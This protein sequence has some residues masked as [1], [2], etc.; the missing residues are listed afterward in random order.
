MSREDFRIV[1]SRWAGR[2]RTGATCGCAVA[3]ALRVLLAIWCPGSLSGR[4]KDCLQLVNCLAKLL[5]PAKYF[6]ISMT[7]PWSEIGGT[8]SM[9][10]DELCSAVFRVLVQKL[11]QNLSRDP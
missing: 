3:V 7:F 6:A 4:V 11:F 8:C 9:F 2:R 5:C 10:K 1:P